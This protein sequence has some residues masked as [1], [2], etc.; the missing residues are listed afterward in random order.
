MTIN[1]NNCTRTW[2]H[3]FSDYC[4]TPQQISL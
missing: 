2:R 3:H 1:I 4:I